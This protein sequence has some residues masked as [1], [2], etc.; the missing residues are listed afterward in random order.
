MLRWSKGFSGTRLTFSK[1]SANF[2][3]SR[4]SAKI[5]AFILMGKTGAGK[6][7]FIKSLGGLDLKNNEPEIDASIDSCISHPLS[8]FFLITSRT[9]QVRQGTQKTTIYLTRINKRK[10]LLLDTPGFDDSAKDNFEVLN[11]IVSQFLA[12]ALNGDE[13]DTRGVIFLHDISETRF[14]GSQRKTLGILKD[15]VGEEN[16]GNVIVGTTMWSPAGSTRFEDQERR[17]QDLMNKH[18]DGIYKTTRI[19]QDDKG[20][21]VGIVTDL[22]AKPALLF[23]FQQEIREPPH[24]VAST[25]AGRKAMPEGRTELEN[26]KKEFSEQQ[27][28]FEEEVRRHKAALEREKQEMRER[29]E[30]EAREAARKREEEEKKHEEDRLKQED[31]RRREFE[32]EKQKWSR[33]KIERALEREKK[34]A[35]KQ[36]EELKKIRDEK[37]RVWKLQLEEDKRKCEE[38]LRKKFEEDYQER[39][40]ISRE[41]REKLEEEMGELRATLEALQQPIKLGW[42]DRMVVSTIMWF[43]KAQ[44]THH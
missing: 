26:G 35:L 42:F 11:N 13:F 34:W 18:W 12:F 27:I 9:N 25:T 23:R 14:G 39:E 7:S 22:L 19:P 4:D 32:E 38:D 37:V 30:E 44:Q 41:N 1:I 2:Y 24:T 43:G 28:A 21:A 16:M 40:R 20:V 3:N 10:I 6:S 36:E 31:R 5:S 8:G 17:E 29:L 33:K 15:L